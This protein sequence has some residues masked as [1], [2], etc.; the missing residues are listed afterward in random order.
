MK[1]FKCVDPFKNNVNSNFSIT[2][3]EWK[4]NTDVGKVLE[5]NKTLN[6]GICNIRLKGLEECSNFGWNNNKILI[7]N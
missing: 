7:L 2:S 4:D 5:Y 3:S 6:L 1:T